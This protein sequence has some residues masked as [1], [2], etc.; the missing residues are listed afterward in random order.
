MEAKIRQELI[1]AASRMRE[2]SYAPY[3]HFTVGAALL[4]AGGRI[5]T[6]CNIEN[7]AFSPGFCA[8]RTAFAKAISEGER[9]FQAIAI[10]GGRKGEQPD[11][12]CPPCGICRQVMRE[13]CTDDFQIILF[14]PKS[15]DQ[16]YTLG[17]LF[18]MSFGP[19]QIRPDA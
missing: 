2:L 11:G 9:D 19:A 3:S 1:S 8:E 10:I 13:F 5:Y 15:G 16:I 17:E 7:A 4:T 14:R 18:P 12:F 6:G